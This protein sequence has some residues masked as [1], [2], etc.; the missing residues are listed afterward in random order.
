VHDLRAGGYSI[1][2]IES[3]VIIVEINVGLQNMINEN[4]TLQYHEVEYMQARG[5]SRTLKGGS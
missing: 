3:S 5:G 2:T 4:A 1:G